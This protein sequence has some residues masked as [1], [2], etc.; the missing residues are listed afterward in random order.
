MHFICAM[1]VHNNYGDSSFGKYKVHA[2]IRGGS[3]G[4]G[5][6]MRI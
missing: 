5:R 2:D 4:R 1:N 3:S 6:Q